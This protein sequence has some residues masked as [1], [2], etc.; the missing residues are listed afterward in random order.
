MIGNE[1][2]DERLGCDENRGRATKQCVEEKQP[3][4]RGTEKRKRTRKEAEKA[5]LIDVLGA[6]GKTIW[7]IRT[8]MNGREGRTFL[9]GWRRSDMEAIQVNMPES[10]TDKDGMIRKLQETEGKGVRERFATERNM[11]RNDAIKQ[12][13]RETKDKTYEMT[14]P[15]REPRNSN[16]EDQKQDQ[17]EFDET[18]R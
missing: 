1:W 10:L 8:C 4:N 12:E 13:F 6:R 17:R 15:T 18:T 2:L 16:L 9:D 3:E 11:T 7:A 5:K 14:K